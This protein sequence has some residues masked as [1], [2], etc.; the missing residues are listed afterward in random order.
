MEQCFCSCHACVQARSHTHAGMQARRYTF[1]PPVHA[2]LLTV[3]GGNSQR[4]C[5]LKGS[6]QE[7]CKLV[8][9]NVNNDGFE[10]FFKNGL[11]KYVRRNEIPSTCLLCLKDAH[12]AFWW[13][14]VNVTIALFTRKFN[15]ARFN[16]LKK[17]HFTKNVKDQTSYNKKMFASSAN[18]LKEL[19][20][21]FRNYL[22]IRED[23]LLQVELSHSR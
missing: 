13:R 22:K 19:L 14:P 5:A 4:K 15:R 17:L 2:I 18:L 6:E 9:L 3:D 10:L 20:T 23:V 7:D 8:Y 12:S 11:C 16:C 21:R 1:P